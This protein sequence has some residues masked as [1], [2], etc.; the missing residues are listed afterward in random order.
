MIKWP[1]IEQYRNVIKNVEMKTRYTG[2]DEAGKPFFDRNVKLPT[3]KFEGTVKLHGSN[4]SIVMSAD[5]KMWCQSR[6]NIIT[7]EKDNAGFARFVES[8]EDAFKVLLLTAK[9][10]SECY[11]SDIVI[12]GEWCGK[13]I[14]KGV[15]ISELPKMFVIFGIALVK[16]DQKTYFTRQDIFEVCDNAR[17]Y[18]KKPK[19]KIPDGSYIYCIYDFP[20]YEC[21]IDFENPHET[22]NELNRICNEVEQEC[23]VAKSFGISG[24]GEG[25]VIRC[26]TIGYEDSGFWAKI[27]GSLHS[28]SKVK[29][30][31]TV[32]VERINNIKELCERLAHN[33]RL[34]QMAQTT[35]DLLNGGDYDIKKIGDFIKAV[36]ADIFKEDMDV[37]AASGFNGKEIAGPIAKI[38]RDFVMKNLEC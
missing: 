11:T 1:S 25:I 6:E 28:N 15:G 31:A 24:I 9:T 35:F 22:Q 37:I 32:D 20:T 10:V 12:F 19:G 8:Q 13:G 3:L 16:D 7:P 38:C 33:G 2:K 29:T 27:K 36:M 34:E 26:T 30:L 17:E 14:Q 5:R 18:V 23:P 21:V 4:A